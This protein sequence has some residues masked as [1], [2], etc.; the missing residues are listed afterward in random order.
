MTRNSSEKHVQLAKDAETMQALATCLRVESED[1]QTT[2]ECSVTGLLVG[3]VNNLPHGVE[4]EKLI[5]SIDRVILASCMSSVTRILA[6]VRH[7]LLRLLC[8]FEV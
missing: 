4:Q 7:T 1:R 5:K 3:N 2:I 6:E 8:P